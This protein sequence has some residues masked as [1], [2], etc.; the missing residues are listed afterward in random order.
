M[1]KVKSLKL[2]IQN[3]K[4]FTLMELLVVI[5]IIAILSALLLVN[6]VGIRQRARDGTRKSD[7]RQLQSA[8]ELYRSDN[9]IYPTGLPPCGSS[10]GV[11]PTPVYMQKIPCDP[12]AIGPTPYYS[13][14]YNNG[15]NYVLR[16]CLENTND[17]QIDNPIPTAPV[18]CN[19]TC[20]S[21]TGSFTLPNP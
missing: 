13:C 16:A 5:A 11:A 3:Y 17:S 7:L 19:M 12:S 4:G 8:L 10:F 21:G 9:G 1:K 20:A 18:G 15:I 6:F 2:K 14:F